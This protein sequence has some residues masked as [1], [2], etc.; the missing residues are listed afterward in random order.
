[1]CTGMLAVHFKTIIGK[2]YEW[3]YNFSIAVIREE[4]T[5]KNTN[6]L[7]MSVALVSGLMMMD[8]SLGYSAT[9]AQ[10]AAKP[11]ATAKPS[12]KKMTTLQRKLYTAAFSGDVATVQSILDPNKPKLIV[13]EA[14]EVYE[15]VVSTLFEQ[16]STNPKKY[17]SMT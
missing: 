11:A 10:T 17:D 3:V 4:K 9:N 6:R 16:L 15:K 2:L 1:V 12:E 7:K 14:T 5:M 13:S 8:A